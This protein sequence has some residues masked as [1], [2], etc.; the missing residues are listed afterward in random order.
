MG[1][2]EKILLNLKQYNMVY[3]WVPVCCPE[4]GHLPGDCT[5]AF[6][7]GGPCARRT[8]PKDGPFPLRVGTA[9]LREG[10][11][12]GV[13]HGSWPLLGFWLSGALDS[14]QALRTT[15]DT[16]ESPLA[17]SWPGLS[18]SQG[19]T[20]QGSTTQGSIMAPFSGGQDVPPQLPSRQRC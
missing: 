19:S 5:G 11:V 8:L 3:G 20:T 2:E 16:E 18:Q 14:S 7:R 9:G 17:S 6:S 15:M 4:S 13:R 12:F 10:T 1:K